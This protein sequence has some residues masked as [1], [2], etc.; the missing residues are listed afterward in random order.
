M[1]EPF[2]LSCVV[3]EFVRAEECTLV[4]RSQNRQEL[5]TF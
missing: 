4:A 2:K 1:I 5:T 3:G